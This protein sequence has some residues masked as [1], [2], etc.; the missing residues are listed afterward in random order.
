MCIYVLWRDWGNHDRSS[1]LSLTNS[2]R[3]TVFNSSQERP[4]SSVE[5]FGGGPHCSFAVGDGQMSTLLVSVSCLVNCWHDTSFSELKC[6]AQIH[7]SLGGWEASWGRGSGMKSYRESSLKEF[8]PKEGSSGT[9]ERAALP[10]FDWR[11]I[12][13]I[14]FQRHT[15]TRLS[16]ITA[17]RNQSLGLKAWHSWIPI[18]HG[19]Y[20]GR[21][22]P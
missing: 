17:F 8:S 5:A 18:I 22:S 16:L 7:V 9:K 12:T 11:S 1:R 10:T 15:H 13:L 6:I 21:S 3:D 4:K 2:F 14:T 20:F 19:P